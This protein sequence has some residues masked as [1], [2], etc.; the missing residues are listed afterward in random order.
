MGAF[1]PY[2]SHRKRNFDKQSRMRNDDFSSTKFYEDSNVY[3]SSCIPNAQAEAHAHIIRPGRRAYL[4][5]F[6]LCF[7]FARIR[8]PSDVSPFS[9]STCCISI[10]MSHFLLHHFEVAPY[11]N[12][13]LPSL[14]DSS[15]GST[16]RS[17]ASISSS[18]SSFAAQSIIG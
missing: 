14:H 6:L 16:S 8:L 5:S 13:A 17:S 4:K 2:G 11:I 12:R 9:S 7:H 10:S 3:H 1:Y 15:V 18:S